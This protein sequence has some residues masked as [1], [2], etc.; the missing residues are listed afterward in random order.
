MPVKLQGVCE[1][2]SFQT[3]SPT[4][5]G[6]FSRAEFMVRGIKFLDLQIMNG[7]L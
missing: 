7:G 1:K 4:S 6:L 2:V 3:D 5:V